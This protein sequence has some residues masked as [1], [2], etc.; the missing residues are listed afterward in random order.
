MAEA[1]FKPRANSTAWNLSTLLFLSPRAR[2]HSLSVQDPEARVRLKVWPLFKQTRAHTK[3]NSTPSPSVASG[4]SAWECVQ[5]VTGSGRAEVTPVY[6][7]SQAHIISDPKWPLTGWCF[8][9]ALAVSESQNNPQR[10][11][12]CYHWE[13]SWEGVASSRSN[14]EEEKLQKHT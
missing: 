10:V 3:M 13:H 5:L 12:V 8:T 11:E 6:S 1:G 7:S 2:S 4:N 9:P 14:W